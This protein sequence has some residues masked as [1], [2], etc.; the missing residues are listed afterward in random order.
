M[1]QVYPTWRREEEAVE[2]SRVARSGVRMGA[3][4]SQNTS[5]SALV[6]ALEV[7]GAAPLLLLDGGPRYGEVEGGHLPALHPTL[8]V[9]GQEG[10]HLQ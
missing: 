10:D 2:E 5:L 6:R 9:G 3:M 8:Q 7:R 4:P 1:V